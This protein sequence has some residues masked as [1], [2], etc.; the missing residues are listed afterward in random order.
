MYLC[1]VI[2]AIQRISLLVAASAILALDLSCLFDSGFNI[3]GSNG[4]RATP[5]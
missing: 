3:T 1:S 2:H 5:Q 4:T